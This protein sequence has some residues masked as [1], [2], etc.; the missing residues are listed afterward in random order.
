MARAAYGAGNRRRHK[1]I[2]KMAKGYRGRAKNCFRVAIERVE[3]GLQYAYRD[4]RTKKRTFRSLWIQRI[5]AGVREH[6]LSYSKF[7]NGLKEANIEMDRKVLAWMAMNDAEGFKS[8]VEQAKK[9]V[10]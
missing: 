9:A 4:R 3:K 6:G 1:K 8:V 7:M 2:L 5:N 10:K